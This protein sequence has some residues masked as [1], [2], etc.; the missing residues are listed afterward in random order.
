M[1][2]HDVILWVIVVAWHAVL[3]AIC[4]PLLAWTY[5]VDRYKAAAIYLVIISVS[6]AASKSFEEIK[7]DRQV[8]ASK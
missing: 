5:N 4:I 3:P 2:L 1:T 6:L 8:E 7:A